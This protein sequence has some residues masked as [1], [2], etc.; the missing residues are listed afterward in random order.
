MVIDTGINYLHEDLKL[1][2]AGGYDFVNDDNYPLDDNGHGTHCAGIIAADPTNIYSVAGVL[3][4]G[5]LCS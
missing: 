5:S 3:L 4:S 2:Y 1:A